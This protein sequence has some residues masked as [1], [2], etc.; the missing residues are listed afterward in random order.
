MFYMYN[1]YKL[2]EILNEYSMGNNNWNWQKTQLMVCV[3]AAYDGRLSTGE[4]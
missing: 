3:A 4:L 1:T 2:V